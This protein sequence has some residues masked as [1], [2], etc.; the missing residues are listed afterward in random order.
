[1]Y[2]DPGQR[3]DEARMTAAMSAY[4]PARPLE[5][6]LRLSFV[7][8]FPWPVSIPARRRAGAAHVRK[9]DLDNLAKFL[10]DCLQAA[11]FMAD[12]RQVTE[13]SARKTYTDGPGWWTVEL[14]P[15]RG[16]L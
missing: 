4:R 14:G 13:I 5:G 16:G 9:P 8:A 3:A 12:D 6:P 11:R 10:M 1:M 15:E 2:K 7:A